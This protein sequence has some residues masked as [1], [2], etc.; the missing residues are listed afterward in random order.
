MGGKVQEPHAC[1]SLIHPARVLIYFLR[2]HVI[3]IV[4]R[5]D[6]IYCSKYIYGVVIS[7]PL[8]RLEV[9]F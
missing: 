9:F 2:I 7:L 4:T 3:R 6:Q 5:A 1:F 8:S